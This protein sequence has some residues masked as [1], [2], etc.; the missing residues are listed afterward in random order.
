MH[1]ADR[2][3]EGYAITAAAVPAPPVDSGLEVALVVAPP[4]VVHGDEVLTVEQITAGAAVVTFASG[5]C[6]VLPVLPGRV[7]LATVEDG[8]LVDCAMV[9]ANPSGASGAS[10]ASG[11][12]RGTLGRRALK[13]AYSRFGLSPDDDEDDDPSAA[14]LDADP[15]SGVYL[16]WTLHDRGRRAELR[17]LV[18]PGTATERLFDVVLLADDSGD[19]GEL[20]NTGELGEL[21]TPDRWARLLTPVPLLARGWALLPAAPARVRDRALS[22]P[23]RLPSHWTLFAA[24]DAARVTAALLDTEESP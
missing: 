7:T 22:F 16:A 1:A 13:A 18:R 17:E 2:L 20:G 14:D 23:P 12:T 3:A 11:G 5:G 6:T 21:G 9:A 24:E 19:T 15:L 4:V 8:R 10:G